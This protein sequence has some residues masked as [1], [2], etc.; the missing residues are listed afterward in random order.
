[1]MQT[2]GYH[3]EANPINGFNRTNC[4]P[5]YQA[6]TRYGLLLLLKAFQ[7]LGYF[8]AVEEVSS[9]YRAV[10]RGDDTLARTSYG[11]DGFHQQ[12]V[13]VRFAVHVLVLS[14]QVHA[15]RYALSLCP[16]QEA[17]LRDT[18]FADDGDSG[19]RIDAVRLI[20]EPSY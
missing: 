6:Q 3:T 2:F 1:M 7:K 4:L 12:P 10:R 14:P 20:E 18:P 8:P 13:A 16:P 15:R 5:S 9:G 17:V 19:S 11:A